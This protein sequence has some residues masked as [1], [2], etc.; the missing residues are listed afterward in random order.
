VN[1]VPFCAMVSSAARQARYF[2][3]ASREVKV[4]PVTLNRKRVGLT[5]CW[6]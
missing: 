6:E 3:T 5:L 1:Q 4:L 2:S